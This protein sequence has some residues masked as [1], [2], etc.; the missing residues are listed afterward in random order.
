[1]AR[2]LLKAV[3]CGDISSPLTGIFSGYFQLARVRNID[4]ASVIGET[5]ETRVTQ[6]KC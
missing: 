5:K 4:A 6:M 2:I 1:M 3:W